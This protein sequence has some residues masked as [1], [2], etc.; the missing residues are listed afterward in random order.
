MKITETEMPTAPEAEDQDGDHE[1]VLNQCA[2]EMMHA[3]ETK[4][5]DKLLD[6]F[7]VLVADMMSKMSQPGEE[8]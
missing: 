5:K 7:Q 2:Q 4:D 3:I 1:A 6:A 8:S